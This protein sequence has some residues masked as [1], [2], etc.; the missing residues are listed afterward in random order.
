MQSTS[1]NRP[2]H[3]STSN[4]DTLTCPPINLPPNERVQQVM[5]MYAAAAL[6]LAKHRPNNEKGRSQ[7]KHGNYSLPLSQ[8][9]CQHLVEIDEEPKL[10]RNRTAFNDNQL[11]KLERCF[12]V[13]QYPTVAVR[14]KLAKE[15]GLPEAKIQVW[16]KNRRAKHRKHLR[17]L[18]TDENGLD[19][20]K[21]QAPYEAS[22]N[23][24]RESLHACHSL[25]T[26]GSSNLLFWH[27]VFSSIIS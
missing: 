1:E 18:P 8:L 17:N 22:L 24:T 13:C 25:Q 2:S 16:Y 15:T 11:E 26:T 14:D 19:G 10:R 20:I 7:R 6:A 5:S 27:F 3:E 21:V 12:Q 23:A 9:H 4:F